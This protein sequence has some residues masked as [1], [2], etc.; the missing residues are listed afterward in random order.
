MT[1]DELDYSFQ[2]TKAL[3]ARFITCEPPRSATKRI[4][5]FATKHRLMVGY[6]GTRTSLARKR[7][8]ARGAGKKLWLIRTITAP[9]SISATSLPATASRRSTSSSS[10]Q[11]HHK[12]PHQGPQAEKWSEYAVGPGRHA[13]P[14]SPAVDE[15]PAIRLHGH[16]RDG[17]PGPGRF[18]HDGRARQV[19]S[20]LQGRSV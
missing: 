1:D 8:V 19:H 6:H 7:S 3:G 16:H 14:G 11:S 13:D 4:A 15:G 5:T 2:I 18:Q 17:A 10:T 9:T 20:V 12:P